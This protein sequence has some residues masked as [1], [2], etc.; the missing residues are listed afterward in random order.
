MIKKIHCVF[1]LLKVDDNI[2]VGDD[3]MNKF[4]ILSLKLSGIKNIEKTVEIPFYKKTVKNNFNP[5]KYRI[6]G[7]YG[8]NGSG[9]TAIMT[10][11]NIL[12]R[13]LLDRNYLSDTANQWEL[14]QI[15]NQKT[16]KGFI[17]IVFYAHMKI[18]PYFYRYRV[19]FSINH[20]GYVVLDSEVFERK[21]S[22]NSQTIY[23]T[24]FE[25]NK[26][27]LKQFGDN[28]DTEKYKYYKEKTLNL[29]DQKSFAIAFMDLEKNA[30]HPAQFKYYH[31][32]TLIVFASS[33]YVEIDGEDDHR[34][35][36]ADTL[37]NEYEKSIYNETEDLTMYSWRDILQNS[38]EGI[39]IPI[40]AFGQYIEEIK[41][42]SS[43]IQVFK[44]NLK[45]IEIDKKKYGAYYIC[46][47][48]LMYDNYEL[49]EEFE[50]RG[51][52]KLMLLFSA[53]DA[54]CRGS[55]VF[56]DELD[57]NINDVY[58]NKLI[59]YFIDYAKGQLCFTAHNLSPMSLLRN[60]KC[61]ISFI[62]SVNTI[63]TWTSNGN[64]NPENAYRN[65]FIKDSPFNVDATDFLGILGGVDEV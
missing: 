36:V 59:E 41:R 22:D 9:K 11:V 8:E 35:Y 38:P 31:I 3:K 20:S 45:K 25:T 51:I 40:A 15:I 29:L 6:K 4:Y 5:D 10:A 27:E 19:D 60:S 55:I 37:L 28:S 56:I 47:R 53:L 64:Q 26:G 65:G 18:G 39:K 34:R 44:P 1:T 16:Q 7:I 54:A 58:L 32:Y 21:N 46:R 24:V 23:R 49:D 42:L 62:S 30:Y 50:S 57:S 12:K 13:V 2:R 33:I 14:K 48:V 17:E 43:F 63:Q 61:S 52:K